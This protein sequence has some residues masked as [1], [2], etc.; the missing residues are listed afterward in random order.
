MSRTE[1][2]RRDAVL[3]AGG[4]IPFQKAGTGYKDLSAYDM[5]RMALSGLMGSS[6]LNPKEIDHVILGNVMQDPRTSNL[7]REAALGAGLPDTLPAHTT[8]M[9]CISS[10][11]A[12]TQAVDQIRSGQAGV[13]LTGGAETLSDLPIRFRKPVRERLMRAQKAKSAGDWFKLLKGLR[14][15]DLLPETPSISEFSTGLTM[16]ESCDRMAAM[17]GV[18]REDQDRYALTSHQRAGQATR[19]ATLACDLFPALPPDVRE[20]ITQDNTW[21]DD[22]TMEDLAKL[23]PAFTRPHGTVTAANASPLTD[24]ASAALV[25]SAAKAVELGFTPL[26]RLCRYHYVARQPDDELLIGPAIAIP[27]LLE[28]E[29]M[30]LSDIDLFELHEAFAGQVLSVLTALESDQFARDRLGRSERVGSIPMD[31][32]NTRGGS[33]SLGHPFGATGARLVITAANRLHEEDGTLAMVA[34][35]AAGGQGHALLLERWDGSTRP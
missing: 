34:A 21:R 12:I 35:C 7:A 29:G 14:P 4:R 17:Y 6:G 28:R 1:D 16:G 30:Q 27:E 32:L 10:N 31:I 5:A 11:M 25:M 18:S 3:V 9:A 22:S 19:N 2:P 26:A 33:L 23:R 13:V 15:S 20:P 24:G 8:T